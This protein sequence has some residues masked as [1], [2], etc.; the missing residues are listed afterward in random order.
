MITRPKVTQALIAKQAGVSGSAVSLALSGNPNNSLAPDTYARILAI[1]DELGY[2]RRFVPAAQPGATTQNIGYIVEGNTEPLR[3]N[4]FLRYRHAGVL[5]FVEEHGFHL[6]MSFGSGQHAIP[7][8]VTQGKVD[9]LILDMACSPEWVTALQQHVPVVMLNNPLATVAVDS[10]MTDNHAGI[11]TAVTLF[12][13]LG[14]RHIAFFGLESEKA[15]FQE[16]LEAYKSRLRALELPVREELIALF[17]PQQYGS[18]TEQYEYCLQ[19]LTH[20]RSLANP[21]TAVM[22]V[23]D[24][25]GFSVLRAARTLQIRVPDELSV[26]GFD[27][28]EFAEDSEPPLASIAQPYEA[29]GALAC[30]L[31]LQRIGGSTKPPMRVRL[32]VDLIARPSLGPAPY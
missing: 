9:G 25:F 23:N 2:T 20:W 15:H 17:L 21:P 6:L 3:H 18:V 27:N 22:A 32:G 1:A 11:N 30:E 24:Q 31:L 16:R 4:V 5:R 12:A 26:I 8:C 10:V 28:L 14:H 19:T 7:D 13:E 29:M